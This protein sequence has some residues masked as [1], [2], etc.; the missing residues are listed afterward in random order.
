MSTYVFENPAKPPGDWFASL[1]S[2]FDP[3]TFGQVDEMP[4]LYFLGWA[5]RPG[6]GG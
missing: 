2:C 1:G 3:V 6:E 5:R 4:A